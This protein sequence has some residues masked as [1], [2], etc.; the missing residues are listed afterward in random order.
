MSGIDG[1]RSQ[2]RI[3]LALAVFGNK[4]A[5]LRRQLFHP[6]DSDAFLRQGRPQSM[7]PAAILIAHEFVGKPRDQL[8]FFLR[9]KSV[10]ARLGL[11]V[12]NALHQAAY[13]NLEELVEVSGG[14]GQ[15]LDAFQQRVARV[16]GLLQHAAVEGKPRGFAI[17]H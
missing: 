12:L 5:L 7:V 10:R 14:D 8:C 16:L 6:Y 1:H 4:R 3:K 13:S 11:A 9:S 17:Q 2:Q 15:K